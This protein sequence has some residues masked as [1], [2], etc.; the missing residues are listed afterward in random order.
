MNDNVQVKRH[1]WSRLPTP[2]ERTLVLLTGARQTGKTTTA[3]TVYP[4]LNHLNLDALEC[5]DQLDQ[6]SSFQWGETVGRAVLD[7]AQKLP[8]AFD[9]LKFAFDAGQVDFSVLLG[10][11]RI[12]LLQ[13]I[14]ESLAGRVLIYEQW[15]LTLGELLTRDGRDLRP[16][17]LDSLLRGS[18][19]DAVLA[20]ARPILLGPEEDVRQQAEKHLLLHGGMPAL[21]H[22]PAQ[23]H[24]TWLK[25]YEA[26]YLERDLADLARLHDLQ[27]FRTFQR[28][29]ALR[30][31]SLLSF[32]ELARDAGISVETARRY[33]EYLRISYQAFL[34]PPF[35]RNLTS[36]VVK[37]PKLY[38]V[39]TGLLRAMCGYGDA[40]PGAVYENYVVAEM[41]KYARTCDAPARLSFYRTRSGAEVDVM[42]ETPDGVAALEIKMSA[43]VRRHDIGGLVRLREALGNEWLGGIVVYRGRTIEEL[44]DGIWAAPSWRLL[45]PAAAAF[46]SS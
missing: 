40:V 1:V 28:L 46:G 39:D 8:S 14:R 19:V 3:R 34:L 4:D 29:A 33:L 10:S 24:V 44:G 12:L 17:L 43:T 26:T 27:P 15:P 25:S 32:S 38:W 9:K 21:L 5:R 37:T 7:E 31:G 36:R 2:E 35:S 30:A 41:L 20:K 18:A 42:I 11:A 23:R 6:V 16:P 13:R 45:S 22:R